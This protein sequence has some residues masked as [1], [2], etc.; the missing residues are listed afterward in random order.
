[1]SP[2]GIPLLAVDIPVVPRSL[3][4]RIHN[5]IALPES[6]PVPGVVSSPTTY[7]QPSQ[8]TDVYTFSSLLCTSTALSRRR[9]LAAAS[10]PLCSP[11]PSPQKNFLRGTAPNINQEYQ[12]PLK[13]LLLSKRHLYTYIYTPRNLRALD[14]LHI[15]AA[16]GARPVSSL[17]IQHRHTHRHT[18]PLQPMPKLRNT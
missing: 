14:P 9:L 4:P 1:M 5:N 6:A 8:T 3:L 2:R 16:L 11:K 10:T 15:Y 18:P 13:L 12:Q 17:V 7:Q